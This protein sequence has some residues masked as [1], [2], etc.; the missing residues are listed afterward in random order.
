M[1]VLA[2]RARV[3]SWSGW[4]ERWVRMRREDAVLPSGMAAAVV[5]LGGGLLVPGPGF[6]PGS[7]RWPAAGVPPED[8]PRALSHHDQDRGK[9]TGRAGSGDAGRARATAPAQRRSSS[10]TAASSQRRQDVHRDLMA[11]LLNE[12]GHTEGILVR[13]TYTV[14]DPYAVCLVFR[15]SRGQ[16]VWNLAREL[17]S[18]A[19]DQRAG[20]GDVV[21]WSQDDEHLTPEERSTF[22]MFE[23][24]SGLVDRLLWRMREGRTFPSE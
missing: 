19:L 3:W 16:V 18:R 24:C 9:L 4:G 6:A 15:T 7:Y 8:H 21:A 12:H 23:Q 1:S 20:T 13:L 17:L 2:A 14:T 22:L 11:W 5:V 10:D